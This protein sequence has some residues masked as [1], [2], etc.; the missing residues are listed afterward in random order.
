MLTKTF[1]FRH[2]GTLAVSVLAGLALSLGACAR[3]P[4]SGKR[5]IM[6]VSE[7]QEIEMGRQAAREVPDELGILK[8]PEVQKMVREVG[9]RIAHSSERPELPW[10]FHVVD[11]SVVN[12]FAFPGGFVYLTRGILTHMNSEAEMVGVLGHE[13]GH[14][15]ARHSAQQIS[16]SQL[17]GV[18]FGLGMIFVPEVRPFGDILQSGLGLLF[19]KFG[20]DDEREADRL[21]VRYALEASY[22]ARRMAE[23]FDVLD[24]MRE[25]SGQALP[26]WLSTH[27][28]PVDREAR[29]LE[30]VRES[31]ADPSTLVVGE[32][33]FKRK[34]EGV[35][36]GDD[37]REGFMDGRVFKHPDLK[38]QV[39]FPQGF[40]VRNTRQA[41]FAGNNEAAFQ[42]TASR[43][44]GTP[45]AHLGRALQG[46]GIRV[47]RGRS[48]SI[49]GFQA[50]VTLFQ[51]N[52][53]SAILN[54]EAAAI[55]DGEMMYELLAYTS[56]DRF[57]RMGN[58]LLGIIESFSRLTDRRALAVEPQRI[59]IVQVPRA[60]SARKALLAAG[61]V[62]EQLEEL[63]LLNHLHLE[64]RVERGTLLKSATKSAVFSTQ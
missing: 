1:F 41:L 64:D 24:R 48:L 50:Y 18:G 43:A 47:G 51:A 49:G 38:F 20:R 8:D 40:E 12:A 9:L 27:P 5:E 36:L 32:E 44:Q 56:A 59:R 7:A 62:P 39:T 34:L 6:L 10:E 63:A 23:F 30:W 60:M 26:S 17:A 53:G 37:P 16:K 31:G 21:G 28:D 52:T 42:L 35:V 54:G 2:W 3:N 19:L 22:D 45:S 29:I 15:T 4:V 25:K 46:S 61:V 14:V 58:M 57:P 55:R 11:S 33:T 13:I